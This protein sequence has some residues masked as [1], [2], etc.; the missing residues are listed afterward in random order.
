M[1]RVRIVDLRVERTVTCDEAAQVVGAGHGVGFGN[2]FG[3]GHKKPQHSAMNQGHHVS[4]GGFG[5][6]MGVWNSNNL[7][8]LGSQQNHLGGSGHGGASFSGGSHHSFGH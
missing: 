3:G 1:S 8:H 6:G 7:G 2:H 4:G 5:H